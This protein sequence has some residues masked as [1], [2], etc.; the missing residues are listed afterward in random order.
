[1][2]SIGDFLYFIAVCVVFL[3]QSTGS[4]SWIAAAAVARLLAY[5]LLGSLGGVIADRYDRR[6]L[7]VGL[8]LVRAGLMVILAGVVWKHGPPAVVIVLTVAN[9][10]A[11]TPYRPAL[12]AATPAL[13][14]ERTTCCRSKC[15]GRGRRSAGLLCRSGARWTACRRQWSGR[16]LLGERPHLRHL[17]RPAGTDGGVGGGQV[18]EGSARSDDRAGAKA[19]LA[20]GLQTVGAES[21]LAALIAFSSVAVFLY[22]F[23]QVVH[24]LVATDRLGMSASGVGVMGAAIGVGG[25]IVAPFTARLGDGSERGCYWRSPAC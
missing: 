23:E 17:G 20:E 13:V 6:R 7:I 16:G 22:G 11:S 5:A 3:I 15:C 9:A 14:R 2:S 21:G 10:A 19:Q 1:M 18:S 12:V 24:V 25:L 8:D 4:P